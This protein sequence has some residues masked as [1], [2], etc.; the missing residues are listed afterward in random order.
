MQPWPTATL[1]ERV[2]GCDHPDQ[3]RM[4]ISRAVKVSSLPPWLA[5]YLRSHE[6]HSSKH[7]AY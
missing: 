6:R 3:R 1:R 5:K 7:H 4:L 2:N